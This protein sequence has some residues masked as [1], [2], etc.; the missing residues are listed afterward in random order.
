MDRPP[1]DLQTCEQLRMPGLWA[2]GIWGGLLGSLLEAVGKLVTPKFSGFK[3]FIIISLSFICDYY[4]VALNSCANAFRLGVYF[5]KM[6]TAGCPTTR[7]HTLRQCVP[8]KTGFYFSTPLNLSRPC[9]CFNRYGQRGAVE[10]HMR[11]EE[12]RYNKYRGGIFVGIRT[13][14]NPQFPFFSKVRREVICS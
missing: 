1:S 8:L 10:I 5:P 12:K 11:P 3:Q 14:R 4:T 9:D 13:S 6:V 7:A 2:T